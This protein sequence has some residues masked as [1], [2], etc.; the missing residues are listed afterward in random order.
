[1]SELTKVEQM[2]KNITELSNTLNMSR[3]QC[4]KELFQG[5]LWIAKYWDMKNDMAET[6][7]RIAI[8]DIAPPREIDG[9]TLDCLV[10]INPTLF[11]EYY[12]LLSEKSKV[13]LVS[14]M[15]YPLFIFLDKDQLTVE[16]S[17]Y[18]TGYSKIG[19]PFDFIYNLKKNMT[20]EF[21]EVRYKM[22]ENYM[23]YYFKYIDLN[24][25]NN[26][27]FGKIT[28]ETPEIDLC[29][30]A[31]EKRISMYQEKRIS[32]TTIQSFIAFLNKNASP[33]VRSYLMDV[34]HEHIPAKIMI[35]AVL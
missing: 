1:M 21:N 20:N 5:K 18:S 35:K 14:K 28:T 4:V 10:E 11:R 23:N 32:V 8:E 17:Y 12:N 31:L 22:V 16:N 30:K 2:I 29:V 9:H 26:L 15:S 7:L 33:E 19:S 13:Q 24:K 27:C 25:V 34:L 3:T 6:M